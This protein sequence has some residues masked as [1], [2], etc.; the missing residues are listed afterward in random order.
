MEDYLMSFHLTLD[1]AEKVCKH[2]GKELS[3]LEEYEVAELVD[4]IIDEL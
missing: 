4:R 1:Q 2:F 3:T